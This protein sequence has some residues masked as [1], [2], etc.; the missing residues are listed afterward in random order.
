MIRRTVPTDR[1]LKKICIHAGVDDLRF[2]RIVGQQVLA[3]ELTHTVDRVHSFQPMPEG[4][5]IV[6]AV[7]AP[8][9][10]T[11]GAFLDPSRDGQV[12]R[13]V[14]VQNIDT[15]LISEKAFRVPAKTQTFH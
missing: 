2:D 1:G 3:G 14:N 13:F 4:W 10:F 8:D 7:T 6:A 5:K 9:D 15:P 12:I 11:A